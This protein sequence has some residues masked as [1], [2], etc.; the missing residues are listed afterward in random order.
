MQALCA[1]ERMSFIETSAL[2]RSNVEQ[3]FTQVLTDIY[4][5]HR[6]GPT[7]S[8]GPNGT[9]KHRPGPGIIVPVN[10]DPK[11]KKSCCS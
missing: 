1:H 6:P 9:D 10:P 7:P 11:P 4:R 3:A 5:S 8:I 2:D